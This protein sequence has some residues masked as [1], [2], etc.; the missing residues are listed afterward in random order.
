MRPLFAHR[1][2]HTHNTHNVA[3]CFLIKYYLS[4]RAVWRPFECHEWTAISSQ[5]TPP[6][7]QTIYFA[8]A[9][10]NISTNCTSISTGNWFGKCPLYF[11]IRKHFKYTH[12]HENTQSMAKNCWR[13]AVVCTLMSTILLSLTENLNLKCTRAGWL[14]RGHR[15][16]K[17]C[18]R[19]GQNGFR[20]C[21]AIQSVTLSHLFYTY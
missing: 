11:V 20:K 7:T 21:C 12:T 13:Y 2:L 8:I 9:V 3:L 10:R 17:S 5:P 4:L 6:T 19:L 1:V 14:A 15:V 16:S 18:A